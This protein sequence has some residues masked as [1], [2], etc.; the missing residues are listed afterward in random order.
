M[1]NW[2][3]LVAKEKLNP[4]SC[5]DGSS[6]IAIYNYK[7]R[8]S[9]YIPFNYSHDSYQKS[10]KQLNKSHVESCIRLLCELFCLAISDPFWL[11]LTILIQSDGFQA[12]LELVIPTSLLVVLPRCFVWLRP[13]GHLHSVLPVLSGENLNSKISR[14]NSAFFRF[15]S[16]A[17]SCEALQ[18]CGCLRLTKHV[19]WANSN[20]SKWK[21]SLQMFL[22]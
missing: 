21:S 15:N 16:S 18:K 7:R 14:S 13:S 4:D 1:L 11:A 22:I 12:V 3:N 8:Y 9:I 6:K 20:Q 5:L 17:L 2:K 10:A 19:Q